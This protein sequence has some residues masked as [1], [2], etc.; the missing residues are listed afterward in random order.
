[1]P[2]SLPPPVTIATF[3]SSSHILAVRSLGKPQLRVHS[4][5]VSGYTA[6]QAKCKFTKAKFL[7]W[8]RAG[9]PCFNARSFPE[10]R[11][12]FFT[13]RRDCRRSEDHH[14]TGFQTN[15]SLRKIIG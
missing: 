15:P 7:N 1:M 10:I 2:H 11:N 12:Q 3:P 5:T 14:L 4:L 8:L 6:G 9:Y 13:H